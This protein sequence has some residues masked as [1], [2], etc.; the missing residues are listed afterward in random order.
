MSSRG[1]VVYCLNIKKNYDGLPNCFPNFW[2]IWKD[3]FESNLKWFSL[4]WIS[5]KYLTWKHDYCLEQCIAYQVAIPHGPRKY[6]F[7]KVWWFLKKINIKSTSNLTCNVIYSWC[8]H[9]GF[10]ICSKMMCFG[11]QFLT[12]R[13]TWE[14]A[15][16]LHLM[17]VKNK[18]MNVVSIEDEYVRK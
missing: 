7:K 5:N 14:S 3:G 1:H 18:V 11:R 8:F 15:E 9:V 13:M 17:N 4:E 12:F 16:F 6:Y 10:S 2:F